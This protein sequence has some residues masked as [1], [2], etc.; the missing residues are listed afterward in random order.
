MKETNFYDDIV[1]NLKTEAKK[2]NTR[3]TK[4]RENEDK[5]GYADM[6]AYIATLKSLRETLNLIS[7]FDWKL[8]YSEYS[9]G[10]E[11]QVAVWEQNHDTQIRN[12]KIWIV[13]EAMSNI[14]NT[15]KDAG[16]NIG[17]ALKSV[18]ENL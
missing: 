14:I 16:N 1:K 7:Q 18:S 10:E 12:H 11:K 2:L 4:I 5:H 8:M 3:L 17:N 6:N 9:S 15:T 13:T